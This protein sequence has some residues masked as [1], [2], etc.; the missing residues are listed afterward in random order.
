MDKTAERLTSMLRDDLTSYASL[1]AAAR[2][3]IAQA[4]FGVAASRRLLPMLDELA[5]AVQPRRKM[6]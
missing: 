3:A 1:K 6:P 2:A 4:L 5:H